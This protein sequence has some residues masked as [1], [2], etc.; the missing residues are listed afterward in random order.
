MQRGDIGCD[1]IEILQPIDIIG[2]DGGTRTLTGLPPQDFKSCV[3]TVPPRPRAR[4]RCDHEMI[5]IRWGRLEV[6]S[7]HHPSSEGDQVQSCPGARCNKA[8]QEPPAPECV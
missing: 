5:P 1:T 7:R 2:A 6:A 3:S 4:L 8:M